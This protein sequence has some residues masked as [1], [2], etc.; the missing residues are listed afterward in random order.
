LPLTTLKN[1]ITLMVNRIMPTVIHK[2]LERYKDTW[3]KIGRKL[4][5][6]SFTKQAYDFLTSRDLTYEDISQFGLTVFA[7]KYLDSNNSDFVDLMLRF[8]V[9][10]NKNNLEQEITFLFK[11]DTILNALIDQIYEED[12]GAFQQYSFKYENLTPLEIFDAEI[13]LLTQLSLS[14]I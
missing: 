7:T 10:L 1:I 11:N 6:V 13:S 2:D 14:E 9:F 4:A 8:T 5:C 3:N 12:F